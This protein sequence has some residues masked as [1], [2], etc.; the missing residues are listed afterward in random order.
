MAPSPGQPLPPR[1]P[2]V[3]I[4]AALVATVVLFSL[5]GAASGALRQLLRVL[6]LLVVVLAAPALTELLT[7]L[8]ASRFPAAP[9]A[10]VRAMAG[11]GGT[12]ALY[13]VGAFLGGAVIALIRRSSRTLSRLDRVGGA[14]F[15]ALK[16]AALASLAAIALAAWSLAINDDAVSRQVEDSALVPLVADGAVALV[17]AV[18]PGATASAVGTLRELRARLDEAM[19]RLTPPRATDGSGDGS[20]AAPIGQAP[21]ASG[22]GVRALDRAPAPD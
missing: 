12:L 9:D 8:V 22:D 21:E 10:V 1:D 15:G 14:L 17:A 2:T 19:T 16:G 4:D 18:P 7:P 5:L 11:A 6:L 3:W 20:G 13:A